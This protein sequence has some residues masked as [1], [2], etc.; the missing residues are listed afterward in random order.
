[1]GSMPSIN[2]ANK[3]GD[4]APASDNIDNIDNSYDGDGD[5]DDYDYDYDE[6]DMGLFKDMVKRLK[7]LREQWQQWQDDDNFAKQVTNPVESILEG[8]SYGITINGKEVQ[9]DSVILNRKVSVVL[10][11]KS[12]RYKEVEGW[13]VEP[14]KPFQ[15][16][17]KELLLKLEE[18][19]AHLYM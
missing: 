18:A 6:D 3:G 1:M 9:L 13:D 16:E 11:V 17:K 10:E 2:F 8:G 19:I 5:D 7:G 15:E 4:T 14:P 12:V